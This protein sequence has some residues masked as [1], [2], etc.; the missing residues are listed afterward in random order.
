MNPLH[1]LQQRLTHWLHPPHPARRLESKPTIPHSIM[2]LF[3]GISLTSVLG[4]RFYNQPQLK[5]GTRAPK[6]VWAS[7]DAEV[8]DQELTDEQRKAAQAGLVQVLQIDPAVNQEIQTALEKFLNEVEALRATAGAFPFVEEDVL[9][10][11]TQRF[12]RAS[13]AVDWQMVLSSV[14]Q[15]TE[16]EAEALA[17]PV[18]SPSPALP[19]LRQVLSLS[20]GESM[21]QPQA[22]LAP[23]NASRSLAMQQAI[24]ELDLYRQQ[25]GEQSIETLL[26]TI[27]VVRDSYRQAQNRLQSN[28]VDSVQYDYQVALLDMRDQ[29]WVDTQDGLRI[30]VERMLAQGF[31][32]GLPAELK[33]NAIMV[34]S[35]TMLPDGTLPLAT[36]LLA[37][38]IKPNLTTDKGETKRLAEQAAEAVEPVVYMVAQGELIVRAGQEITRREFVLLDEFNESRRGVDWQGLA[39]TGGLVV[40]S[41]GIFWL[42]KRRFGVRLRCRDRILLCLLSLSTPLMMHLQQN[43]LAA[44][45]LL[46]S[47][48]FSPALAVTHITL[49]TG[50][51]IFSATPWTTATLMSWE[52]ILAGAAG[53]I[54]AALVAGRLRSR[55]ELALLGGAVGLTQGTVYFV[56]TLMWSSTA[57]VIW[58]VILPA[59]AIFGL[60]GLAWCIVALGLSPYLERLFDLVTPI[61]LA[62]LSNP[63]RPLLKRLS[64]EAPGTF[65][66]TLFV[67][68][69]AEAAAR[70]LH[71]NV[72]L[73]R[74]GTLYHDIGKM[75]DPLGFI[76][77]QMGGPNKHD[78]INDP[79]CSATIIKKH[80]SEG[81]AI[82]RRYNLPEA[83]Q[84]F[85]P[86]HQGTI[87]ISYF[88]FQAK[89]R[90]Q[91]EGIDVE[92]A[93]FRY[94]GPIPQSRETGIV[95]LADA[96]EAALRSLKDATPETA[97]SMVKKIFRAR[98][99]DHQLDESGL[100]W[101]ELPT[102]AEVFVRVWQQY[103]H[104]RI[105]YPK[106][107]LDPR[108][109][110][111]SA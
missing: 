61:R 6:S 46:G 56:V 2:V 107:A 42:A 105:A 48:F 89:Q 110:Q 53:G 17:E 101:E 36:A 39:Q 88:Y 4:Y 45:G 54:V 55:E 11:P 92:E 106:A 111:S 87:L 64:T 1:S 52:S 34:Q 95:M 29:A 31:P 104:Q 14:T 35:Q 78:E 41:M 63:N 108:P 84:D 49:M 50:L 22:A 9:S 100:R 97:L 96:C 26:K 23:S 83:L 81:L 59:A 74:A 65:Q 57:G 71:C 30:I 32:P 8:V 12:L 91:S 102:I 99:Q 37:E 27:T 103:N 21:P 16:T 47:S 33:Q 98:W 43:N 18:S 90:A 51:S 79:W 10:L 7:R 73:V 76:E 19:R 94:A 62:E 77:N 85:I 58:S 80:V 44:V 25:E 93:Q 66:H 72:E 40:G 67:A 24:A 82:A 60:S 109:S 28:E 75:H 3:I 69:L 70:E 13:S 5:E 86:E 20:A 15:S 38:M 68:T